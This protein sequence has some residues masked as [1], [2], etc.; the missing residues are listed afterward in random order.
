MSKIEFFVLGGLDEHGKDCYALTI[1]GDIYI[2]NCGII[3]PPSISLGVKKIIPDFTWINQNKRAIKGI[4]VGTPSYDRFGSLEFF[5]EFI[6]NV[7]IYV[8]NIGAVI[9]NTYFSKKINKHNHHQP[10]LNIRTLEPLKTERIGTVMV[11]PFRISNCI[12]RSLG[13]IFNTSDG[14][15]IYI[16]DF[17]VS[18]NKNTLFE[19]EI[20]YINKFTNHKNLLLIVGAGL[21]GRSKGFTNPHHRVAAY[22]E[23]IMIDAPGRILVACYDHDVYKILGLLQT[24]ANKN[25]PINIYSHTFVELFNYLNQNNYIGNHKLLTI[26]DTKIDE[27]TNAVIVITGTSQRLFPKL[28]KIINDD[29]PKF[30]IKDDDTF[31][32]A[33]GT[34]SGFEVFEAEVFDNVARTNINRI[35]KLPREILPVSAS[36]EDHKFLVEMLKPK[37]II[38]VSGL[39]MDFI[40]YQKAVIQSGFAKQNVLILENGRNVSFSNGELEPKT[41]FVNLESQYIGTQGVLDVGASSMFERDQMKDNGVVLLNFLYS[42]EE[43]IIKKFNYDTVGVTNINDTNRSIINGIIEEC[44]KTIN[45]IMSSAIEKNALDIKEIKMAIRKFVDK[46]F[47]K[48]FNKK[49][50]VLTTIIFAKNHKHIKQ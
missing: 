23:N 12:P 16:D 19:D 4:F 50:L 41:K 26:D 44:N 28:E 42:K 14:A 8:S 36:N 43:K 25:I 9:L 37:Y 39:Y 46:H 20:M 47:E 49:P 5:Y 40:E 6:P 38:P 45:T 29:D 32:F 1:N 34:I 17:I 22:F 7:P 10:K 15:V 31:I 33:E 2:I 30:H 35:Y 13:L 21:A 27:S 24:T 11:T 48:K 3:T 18:S